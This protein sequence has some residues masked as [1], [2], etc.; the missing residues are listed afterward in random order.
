MDSAVKGRANTKV[1][2]LRGVTADSFG[3]PADTATPVATDVT[4]S[5][6]EQRKT[7]T[8]PVDGVVRRVRFYTGRLPAGTDIRS[9]DRIKDQKTNAIYIFDAATTPTNA[10]RGSDVVLDLR[11]VT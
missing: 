9:G 2:I 3:D 5:I 11:R 1:T 6:I 8:N 10:V 4:A 7:V